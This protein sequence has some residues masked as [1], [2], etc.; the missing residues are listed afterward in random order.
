[1]FFSHISPLFAGRR[2]S[3]VQRLSYI[4]FTIYPLTSLFILMYAF[5]PVMW[6]LPTEILVQRPYT[7]YIVYLIIVIAMIHVIGMF[8]IMWAGITWV[9]WWHNEQCSEEEEA[10]QRERRVCM[11]SAAPFSPYL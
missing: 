11:P 6:L 3:L 8:E 5:C 1:M 9:D 2:L 10:R 4:N 7:R